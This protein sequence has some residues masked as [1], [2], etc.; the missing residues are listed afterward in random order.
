MVKKSQKLIPLPSIEELREALDYDPATGVLTWK[1]PG[2]LQQNAHL[3]GTRAGTVRKDG[4]RLIT[5]KSK[6]LL[7]SRVAWA[8]HHGVWPRR[9]ID[10][11]DLDRGNDS[12]SNL[13]EATNAQNTQNQPGSASSG[14]KG[15]YRMWNGTWYSRIQAEGESIY[16]GSF[17][18]SE[19]AAAAY[20]AASAR[21]HGEFGRTA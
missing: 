19:E 5:V 10:H 17:E 1:K 8:I 11:R 18:T 3:I 15:A 12:L 4:R 7:A 16:L 21:L 14:L 13:R 9:L 6:M 2:N 20:A